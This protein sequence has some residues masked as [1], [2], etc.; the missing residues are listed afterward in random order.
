MRYHLQDH[1]GTASARNRGVEL[2]AGDYLAFID[3]DDIWMPEKLELQFAA[4]T[5]QPQPDVVFGHVQQFIS[6]EVDGETASRLR[7]APVPVPGILPT[8]MLVSRLAFERVGRFDAH[9]RIGEWS[10][11]YVRAVESGIRM[12]VLP[13]VVAR[14]RLHARNKGRVQRDRLSE[15]PQLLKASLD[16]RRARSTDE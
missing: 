16:R 4:L 12:L 9:W 11:W 10:N 7:C 14:R 6:P 15:Y 8:T 1:G 13:E 3:Q 5:G 2:A